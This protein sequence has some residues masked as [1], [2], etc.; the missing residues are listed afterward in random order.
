MSQQAI[1]GLAVGGTVLGIPLGFFVAFATKSTFLMVLTILL[2]MLGPIVFLKLKN[3][4]KVTWI[5]P[6]AR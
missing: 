2:L 3:K 4:D 6:T 5:R 1:K